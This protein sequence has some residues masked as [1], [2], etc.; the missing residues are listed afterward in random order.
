MSLIKQNQSYAIGI[1]VGILVVE[2][3]YFLWYVLVYVSFSKVRQH[4]LSVLV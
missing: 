1:G 2:V 4:M 3:R